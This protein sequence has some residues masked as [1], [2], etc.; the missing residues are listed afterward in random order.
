[1]LVDK[2]AAAALVAILAI[3]TL[4]VGAALLLQTS[5][6]VPTACPTEFSEAGAVDTS[7]PGLSQ[8][9]RSWRIAGG[10][11]AR[12]RPGVIAAFAWDAADAPIVITLDPGTG[13]RCRLL[14]FQ[15]NKPIRENLDRLEWSPAGDALAIGIENPPDHDG[16][17]TAQVLVW[18]R[19]RLFR[20]WSGSGQIPGLA[21][22]PDGRSIAL[23]I[24][25]GATPMNARIVFADGAP[26]REYSAQPDGGNGLR[27]S[28]DGSRWLVAQPVEPATASARNSVAIVDIASGR[29][30]PIDVGISVSPEGWIDD[31][32]VLLFGQAD[33]S[34]VG[35]L[36]VPLVAPTTYSAVQLP[37]VAPLDDHRHIFFAPGLG[38]AFY[39]TAKGDFEVA[40]LAAPGSQPIRIDVAGG[41]IPGV[42]WAPDASRFVFATVTS[43][44]ASTSTYA[45]WVVDADGT[46]ARQLLVGSAWPTTNSWQPVPVP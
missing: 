3:G 26:D 9:Q 33:G 10:T 41:F 24:A 5:T 46:D 27:W 6:P 12:V 44:P 11:P 8:A 40:D 17:A 25:A 38:R 22:A 28:P 7:V 34:S 19:D 21:W 4:S 23:W 35:Y 36:D 29:V 15:D 45:T 20:I 18:T 30:A 32:R 39:T 37:D 42:A 31:G 14:R 13:A 16:M 1:M 43:S 2:L